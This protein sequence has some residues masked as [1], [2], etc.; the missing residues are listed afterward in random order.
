MGLKSKIL[1]GITLTAIILS[2]TSSFYKS[3][4][5]EDFE[6]VGT[7]VE[8]DEDYAYVWF[9]YENQE[10]EFEIESNSLDK[11]IS[12]IVEQTGTAEKNLDAD[13]IEDLEYS[14]DDAWLA[15]KELEEGEI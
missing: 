9:M 5:I 12:T 8:V 14:Y 6:V 1:L 10:Y 2:V 13:F 7:W 3:V 11:I 15:L 4:I